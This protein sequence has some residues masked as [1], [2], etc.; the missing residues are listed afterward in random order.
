MRRFTDPPQATPRLSLTSALRE[1]PVSIS[2]CRPRDPPANTKYVGHTSRGLDPKAACARRRRRE[3]R[4]LDPPAPKGD[5]PPP[6]RHDLQRQERSADRAERGGHRRD[7]CSEAGVPLLCGHRR[8]RSTPPLSPATGL[9]RETRL[10][11][12]SP[13]FNLHLKTA[14]QYTFLALLA[15][16]ALNIVLALLPLF[17]PEDTLADIPL[18]PSQRKLLN[19]PPSATAPTPNAAYSTPPRYSRT[20]SVGGSVASSASS[21]ASLAANAS[22]SPY[23]PGPSPLQGKGFRPALAGRRSSFGSPSPL[24]GGAGVKI[25]ET[26]SPSPSGK[27]TSVGLNSKWLY[28][29]GRRSSGSWMQ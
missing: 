19:L 22:H 5:R 13:R 21:R 25:F 26:L 1:P 15:L 24:G 14:S 3:P 12:F 16:P 9:S 11:G 20:P 29:K 23:S 2:H 17:R 8:V 28:E 7:V 10:T 27:R 4:Q 18:T 6:Q